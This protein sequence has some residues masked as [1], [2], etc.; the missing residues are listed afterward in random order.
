LS[1]LHAHRPVTRIVSGLRL[2]AAQFADGG[3]VVVGAFDAVYW[4]EDVATDEAALHGVLPASLNHLELW[5]SGTLS[6]RARSEL[7]A[8]GWEVH[9]HAAETPAN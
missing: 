3:I 4:T 7:T 8:R 9:D 5:I 2:P 6:P 1:S